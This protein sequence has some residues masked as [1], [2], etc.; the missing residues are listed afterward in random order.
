MGPVICAWDFALNRPAS[1]ASASSSSSSS[2]Y[3]S[4]SAATPTP[5]RDAANQ[6]AAFLLHIEVSSTLNF[7]QVR[8]ISS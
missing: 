1:S 3:P 2:S 5:R 8:S 4:Y 6:T 7:T